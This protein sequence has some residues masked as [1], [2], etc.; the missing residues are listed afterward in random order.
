MARPAGLPAGEKFET[1]MDDQ[2]PAA[3][4]SWARSPTKMPGGSGIEAVLVAAG[5]LTCAGLLAWLCAHAIG[6]AG[7]PLR[8]ADERLQ[9]VSAA[10][11]DVTAGLE[12]YVALVRALAEAAPERTA[13]GSFAEEIRTLALDLAAKLERPEEEIATLR[14]VLEPDP[15]GLPAEGASPAAVERLRALLRSGA[16]GP[17]PETAAA[18]GASE[19]RLLFVS[20]ERE[21]READRRRAPLSLIDLRV[22]GFETI[23]ER[24]GRGAADRV[25]RGVARAIRSQLRPGDTCVRDAGGSFLILVPGLAAEGVAPLAARIEAAVARHKFAPERGRTLRLEAS[26]CSATFPRDGRSYDALI[27]AAR[28]R[29]ALKQPAASPRDGM[30]AGLRPYP[31]RIDAPVN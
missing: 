8:R 24:F 13:G 11:A 14:A 31:N 2:R 29:R 17:A 16:P 19:C 27:T 21:I 26:L 7:A 25:L 22:E 9:R 30:P 10:S 3:D 23:E 20:F 15:S 6:H 28:A 12:A 5:V 4:H 1:E 18:E